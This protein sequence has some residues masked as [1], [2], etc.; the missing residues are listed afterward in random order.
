LNF[1]QVNDKKENMEKEISFNLNIEEMAKVGL[2][3]GHK[4]SK[5]HPKMF[6]F[7]FGVRNNIH[8]IDLE[9][10]KEKF[11]EALKFI[12]NLILQNKVILFVGT[13]PQ[14]KDLVKEIATELGFPYVNERWLGGTF[15][16]FE[17]IKKRAEYLKDL[18]KKKAEGFFEK[19]TKK[20]RAEIEKKIQ[21]LQKKFGGIK[22]LEKLPDA[23]FVCDMVKD[24]LAVKEAREKGVKIIAISDTNADPTLAD[25]PIPANDDAIS[26]V[27]YILE[28][29]KEVILK[30][31]Q[32]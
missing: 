32:K 7:I 16:N 24:K 27:K 17:V 22:N 3:F 11:E 1:F 30:I 9:K 12:Q 21:K 14:I 18:E 19:Y 23:I 20:E 8:I 13:K 28:K 6:P 5:V 4:T 15:T 25:Y 10:T 2:H 26:S 31:K 29:V